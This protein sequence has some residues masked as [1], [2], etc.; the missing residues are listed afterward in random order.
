M[1]KLVLWT[2]TAAILSGCAPAEP[3][4][5]V[6]EVSGSARSASLTIQNEQ[7]GTEQMTVALPWSRSMS[8]QP[9]AFVYVSAQNQDGSGS[10]TC[11]IKVDGVSLQSSTS[12]GAYVIAG[13]S[14][15]VPVG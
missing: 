3:R 9:G 2:L 15:S 8:V 6:Y 12:S 10:V 4:R 14:G 5:V 7:G 1:K 11:D 13:C